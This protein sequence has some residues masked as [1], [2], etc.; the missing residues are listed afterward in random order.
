MD[1]NII[2]KHKRSLRRHNL[3]RM[4]AKARRIGVRYAHPTNDPVARARA[5]ENWAKLAEHLKSCSCWMCGRARHHHGPRPQEYKG[6][7]AWHQ[8]L[9]DHEYGW[10]ERIFWDAGIMSQA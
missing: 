7:L 8:D 9:L 2:M 4:K 1:R 6:L 10:N 3:E 5:A